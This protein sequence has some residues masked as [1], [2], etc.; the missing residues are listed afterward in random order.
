MAVYS[1]NV[2]RVTISGTC[3]TGA[4]IWSTGFWLGSES[5]DAG[6]PA[7]SADDIAGY[8]NTFFAGAANSISSQYITNQVKVS[9][10]KA[11]D[12][13]VDLTKVD[14]YDLSPTQAG[15]GSNSALPPQITLAATLTSELQRGTASKGRMYL[16][17]VNVAVT[18][19]SGKII[20]TYLN[21]LTTALKTMFDAIN[22]D[23]DIPDRV[24][25][26]S[27][28]NK[29]TD[30]GT[31]EVHYV[32]PKNTNVT[33]LR[34]GDVYDTQRRRRNDLIETYTTKVLA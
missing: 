23:T 28:G 9:Q 3:F 1:H 25:L 8:W 2:N 12:G 6:D 17:G 29:V 5:A 31:G 14:I 33:G 34:A 11:S 20:S 27:R 10:H 19:T 16:P 15:G 32:L 30:A 13:K 22:A 21:T 7:G 26:V 18:N 4:E 24:V